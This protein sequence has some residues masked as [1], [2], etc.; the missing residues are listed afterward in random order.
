M[1]QKTL[2]YWQQ[3]L[4]PMYGYGRPQYRQNRGGGEGRGQGGRG[5]Y[6]GG[7]RRNNLDDASAPL[8]GFSKPKQHHNNH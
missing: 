5:G 3:L 1:Q 7:Q 6:R 2:Q 4:Q 8:P